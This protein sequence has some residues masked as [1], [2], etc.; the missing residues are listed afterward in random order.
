MRRHR[1]FSWRRGCHEPLAPRW[2]LRYV[3]GP[4]FK[5]HVQ[6]RRIFAFNLYSWILAIF[7]LDADFWNFYQR[8]S[9]S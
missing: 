7:E 4:Q 2:A 8:E 6:K 9:A 1:R 5:S 3:A